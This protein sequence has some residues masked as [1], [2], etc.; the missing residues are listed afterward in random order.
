MKRQNSGWTFPFLLSLILIGCS[1]PKI[2]VDKDLQKES[3]IYEVSGRNGWMVN[4]H[5]SFGEYSTGKVNRG[6]IKGYDY[7]FIVRFTGSKEK[8]GFA[9]NDGNG[10]AAEVFCLGK[11]RE[12]DLMLFHDYF[13]VNLKTNDAFTGSVVI[14]DEEVFDFFIINLNQNN[15]FKKTSGWIQGDG[16]RL[17]IRAVE[18][19]DNN[20]RTT[21]MQVPGFEFLLNHKVV[22]AVETLNRGRIW[23]HQELDEKQKL[24]IAGVASSLLL[25]SDLS[26]HND[27]NI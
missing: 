1:S 27:Q 3:V 26:E 9:I 15:W 19:L 17:E 11:L 25:R 13:D 10:N 6:W 5:L 20:Q 23:L 21:S 24:L 18:K 2:L 7:P 4:Q 14:N 12:Q 22:G 8:L 16:V